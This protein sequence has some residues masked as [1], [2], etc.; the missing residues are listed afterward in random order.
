MEIGEIF[1]MGLDKRNNQFSKIKGKNRKQMNETKKRDRIKVTVGK[2]IFHVFAIIFLL[3]AGISGYTLYGMSNIN[4]KSIEIEEVW[5]PTVH[6]LGE[7]RFYV[8]QVVAYQLFY[9]NAKSIGEMDDF[10]GRLESIFE[11]LDKLFVKYES[12]SLTDE[13]KQVYENFQIEWDSYLQVH[14]EVLVLSRNVE[15]EAASEMIKNSRKQIEVVE[16]YLNDLVEINQKRASAAGEAGNEIV[17]ETITLSIVFLIFA[18][19]ASI[20]M[21]IILTRNISRPLSVISRSVKQVAEGNLTTEPIIIKNRDEIGILATDFNVMSE[22]LK[23]LILKVIENSQLVAATSE[24]LSASSD[25]TKKATEQ[26]SISIQEVSTGT[27]NQVSSTTHASSVGMAISKEMEE[28][29]SVIL[30]VADLT[31]IADQ[32]TTLGQKIVTNTIAQ[33]SDVQTKVQLTSKAVNSLGEKSKEIGQIVLLITDIANQT[34][35]L[36]LNAAIEASRAGEQGRGFAVV[37]NEVRKLAEQSGLAANDIK[38]IVTQI[39][40]E[41]VNSVNTMAKGASAVDIGLSMVNKTG[42][43]FNEILQMIEEVASQSQN[44]TIIIEQVK[45]SLS[46]MVKIVEDIANISVQTAGNS[47]E[48][49]ASAEEQNASMEEI[50]LSSDALSQKALD[51]QSHVQRFKV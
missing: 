50:A 51:L 21:G 9:A 38:N 18:L 31:E 30:R 29:Y 24:E 11:E 43:T 4:K 34:N 45:T 13:E 22:K 15:L 23:T 41:A 35:L 10:E 44:A 3:I 39:Q 12:G 27:E 36:A 7:M 6:N 16:S 46:Q 25:Q 49:A 5:L 26:I 17:S 48:V 19:V 37:A 40:E 1:L 47:E 20:I 42:E 32:H 8:E 14:E 33:M 2:K 28:V